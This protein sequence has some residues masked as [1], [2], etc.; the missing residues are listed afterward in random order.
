MKRNAII[1]VVVLVL[2]I[3]GSGFGFAA[4]NGVIKIGMTISTTGKYTFASSQGFKGVKIWAD[5]INKDGGLKIGGEKRPVK[6]VY[7]DDR[8][9]K[10]T[11]V[12]LYEKLI[13]E[14]KVDICFAPFGSTLTGAA[15]A[16]TAKHGKMLIIWSAASDAVYAQGYKYIVS[17]TET[18]VS[19]MPKPEVDHMA[20]L[21]VKKLAI[22][23]V[24]EPFPAGLA[25]HAK[26]LAESKG[27]EVVQYEKYSPGTKDFTILLQKVKMSKA[28][29]FYASAYMDDQKIMVRQMKEANLMFPYVYMVYSGMPQWRDLGDDGLFIFGH[30][31][32]HESLNWKV[33]AGMSRVEFEKVFAET[34]PNAE[35]PPDF[36]TSLS[37]G[38]GVLLGLFVEKANSLEAAALKKVALDLSGKVTV[39]TGPYEIDETGKQLLMPFIVTQ[40]HKENGKQKLVLLFP[41]EVATGDTVYPI[42]GWQNR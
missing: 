7:Y 40:V 33:N 3:V 17:A 42:P 39:M 29:A 28:D 14:D 4:D 8:S 16:I 30:T 41:T 11:V 34:F 6:L 22:V 1:G 21:G 12:K 20:T 24:D 25:K 31:L 35:N 36:Q 15:A 27:I 32:Y 9:D 10:E 18:P 26:R 13:N 19:L 23:Y 38:A 37:Y 5:Q 2:L